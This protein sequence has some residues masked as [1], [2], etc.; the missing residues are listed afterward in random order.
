MSE[1]Q[2]VTERL[3]LYLQLVEHINDTLFKGDQQKS[4]LALES[5]MINLHPDSI[6]RVR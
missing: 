3:E 4:P 2:S 5:A 6:L 1:I